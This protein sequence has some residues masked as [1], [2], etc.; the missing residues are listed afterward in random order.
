MWRHVCTSIDDVFSTLWHC[1]S[2]TWLPHFNARPQRRPHDD[3]LEFQHGHFA[4]S[5]PPMHSTATLNS[6]CGCGNLH[7]SNFSTGI[8]HGPAGLKFLSTIWIFTASWHFTA[9][10]CAQFVVSLGSRHCFVHGGQSFTWQLCSFVWWHLDGIRHGSRHFGGL[11]F[12]SRPQWTLIDVLPQL[13]QTNKQI[14]LSK[15]DTRQNRYGI[16]ENPP[17][18]HLGVLS[19]WIALAVMAKR[20]AFMFTTRKHLATHFITRRTLAVTTFSIACMLVTLFQSFAFS[21]A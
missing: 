13:L 4:V 2:Q 12:F 15:L 9:Q 5:W 3:G 18:F 20:C 1:C 8:S 21:F 14:Q 7:I 11:V 17:A 6:H 19:A 10:R 16:F